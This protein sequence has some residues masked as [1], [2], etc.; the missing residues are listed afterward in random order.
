MKKIFLSVLFLI[1]VLSLIACGN[2]SPNIEN[3]TVKNSNLTDKENL[4]KTEKKI[5]VAYFSRTGNTKETALQ[6]QRNTGGEIFEIQPVSPYPDDYN[7]AVDQAK[8]E[9]ESDYRP[10]L[11]TKV[12]NPESYDIIFIGYPIWWGTIPGPVKTFLSENDFSGK[13]LVPFCTHGG[14]GEAG[15]VSDIKKI[16]PQSVIKKAFVVLGN[17]AKNSEESLKEWMSELNLNE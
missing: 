5:L 1:T 2:N 9:L 11:K 15:S 8:K 7:K 13:I 10:T 17:R 12:A 6:I 14:S 4:D 16:Y 3:N